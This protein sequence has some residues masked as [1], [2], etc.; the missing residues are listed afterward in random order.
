[1]RFNLMYRAF[2]GAFPNQLF[3]DQPALSKSRPVALIE[4]E[5]FFNQNKFHQKKII[6]HRASMKAYEHN[7]RSKG[8][9][10][11]CFIEKHK[12]DFIRNPRMTMMVRQVEKMD[13]GK[14][15]MMRDLREEFLVSL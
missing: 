9:Q 8:Y 3:E 13:A 15:N 7:L 4:D 2:T 1:M 10:Y 11:W 5:L 12:N 6:L 14:L